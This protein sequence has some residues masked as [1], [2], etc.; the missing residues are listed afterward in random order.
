M[1]LVDTRSCGTNTMSSQCLQSVTSIVPLLVQWISPAHLGK[2]GDAL[3]DMEKASP[4][5]FEETPRSLLPRHNA[6]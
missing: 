1:Y 2:H 5:H 4:I 3:N 6:H